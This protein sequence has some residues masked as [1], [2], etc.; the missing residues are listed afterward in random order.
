METTEKQI[1]EYLSRLVWDMP[2]KPDE[3][4]IPS[5]DANGN[6]DQIDYYVNG[7]LNFTHNFT[8]NVDGNLTI[9]KLIRVL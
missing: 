5:Y 4:R 6:P 7:V 2:V 9:K 1:L 3:M 8:W